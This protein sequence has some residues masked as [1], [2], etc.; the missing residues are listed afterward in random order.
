MQRDLYYKSSNKANPLGL[1]VLLLITVI[2]GCAI[3][4]PYLLLVRIIP[5]FISVSF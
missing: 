1:L 5:L 2:A 4:I 3:S